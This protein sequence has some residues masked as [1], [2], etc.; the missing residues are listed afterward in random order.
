VNAGSS[1]RIIAMIVGVILIVALAALFLSQCSSTLTAKKQGEV[2]KEQGQ[3]SVGAGQ[4]AMNTLTNVSE[5]VT[6]ADRAVTQ[7]QGEVRSAPETE[8]G[9]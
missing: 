1:T 7:G 5:N 4:E 6:A 8:K 9:K 2:N 3:A